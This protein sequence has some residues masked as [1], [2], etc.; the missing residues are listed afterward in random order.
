MTTRFF[1]R[2]SRWPP[3][4]GQTGIDFII[5][6]G[7]FLLTIAFVFSFVP[8]T[9]APFGD[10]TAAP[11]VADR[12]ADELVHQAL[13]GAN[14][15]SVLDE[16][17]T[18]AFFGYAASTDCHFDGAGQ[19]EDWLAVPPRTTLNVTVEKNLDGATGREVVCLDAGTITDCNNGGDRLAYGAPPPQ[20][21]GSVATASRVVSLGGT[22]AVVV[23]RLW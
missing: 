23:V 6:V 8:G 10:D 16:R 4:R 15:P 9:L 14:G 19:P 3:D 13:A 11:V 17:C 20:T 12:I 18:L 5:G 2:S 7:I 1:P 21:G 22:D